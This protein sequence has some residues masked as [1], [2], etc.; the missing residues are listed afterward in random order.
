MDKELEMEVVKTPGVRKAIEA[1]VGQKEKE[2]QSNTMD[3][4]DMWHNIM[5]TWLM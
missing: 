2:N 5:P 3:T 4:M 1:M